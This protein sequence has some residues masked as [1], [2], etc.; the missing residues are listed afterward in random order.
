MNER[1][2]GC[3]DGER[4]VIAEQAADTLGERQ[5]RSRRLGRGDQDRGLAVGNNEA[6]AGAGERAAEAKP[7]AAQALETRRAG[8]RQAWRR[9]G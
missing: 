4:L 5:R 9:D 6:R 3:E 1:A 2:V 7:E 8:R